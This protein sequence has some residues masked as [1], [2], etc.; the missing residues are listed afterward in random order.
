MEF[1]L[2]ERNKFIYNLVDNNNYGLQFFA[3]KT[4]FAFSAH[5]FSPDDL[6][7]AYHP[8]DLKFREDVTLLIDCAHRGL[9]VGACG[10]DTLEKYRIKDGSFRLEYV[11][12]PLSGNLLGRL[13]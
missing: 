1:I 2:M 4:P 6:T 12:T 8:Y 3:N 13:P 10:P 9:G 5:N 11:I 7:K